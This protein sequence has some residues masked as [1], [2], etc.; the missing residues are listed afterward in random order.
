MVPGAA[1][2]DCGFISMVTAKLLSP[3]GT[4][5]GFGWYAILAA[6][7]F[8][9]MGLPTAV[10]L[11]LTALSDKTIRNQGSEIAH[12]ID[13]MRSFYSSDV[14]GRVLKAEG[15]VTTSHRYLESN[16][17]I[18]IPA[19]MS[20][21]LAKRIGSTADG[22]SYRF[23]SDLPFKGRETHPF[24][25]FE[26]DALATLRAGTAKEVVDVSG[27][28]FDRKLRLVTPVVMGPVC[29]ACHNSHPESPK[30]DWKVGDVRGIQEVTVA[31]PIEANVFAFKY[32]LAYFGLLAAAGLSFLALQRRQ[33]KVIGAM[34]RELTDAN[35]FLATVSMKI[36]KYIPPHVY[37]N[38]FSGMGEAAMSTERKKLT[39]F[40]SDI[41]ELAPAADKLQ[42]E[43]VTDL[44]NTYLSAM[45]TIAE[46]HG[47]VVDKFVGEAVLVFFGAPESR[48]AAEDARACVRMA[49][50]MKRRLHQLNHEWRRR[51]IQTTL[52]A[53][54]GI[55]T[56]YCNIGSFGSNE[57]MEYT[58]VGAEANLAAKLQT[59]ASP[60]GIVLSGETYSLVRDLVK[61]RAG[62]AFDMPG[63]GHRIEP[64]AIEGLDEA[65]ELRS[66]VIS[67]HRDGL[68]LYI[69]MEALDQDALLKARAR[70]AGVLDVID[71]E[72][73][74]IAKPAAR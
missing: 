62:A 42:P 48:G 2:L 29:V 66:Q 41:E 12:I 65:E 5:N 9:V 20:I 27:S 53:R 59:L 63:I 37:K 32:L 71:R 31:Q 51:G 14:V 52:Q 60:S 23:I 38:V 17:A 26:S 1:K 55:N 15:K 22:V 4:A 43:D 6:V 19:T 30:T 16:G 72:I 74:G 57:R 11:D 35:D 49:V 21:E 70:L 44:I 68:D 3:S 24:D 50:A 34:N 10:W 69:D 28:L 45:A 54:M 13:S 8:A 73:T 18:P 25:T 33:A 56:G 64:Y 58:I 47:G 46:E 40:Y 61:A 7:L 67:E 36:A 39:M